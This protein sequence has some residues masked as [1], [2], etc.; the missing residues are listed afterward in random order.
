MSLFVITVLHPHRIPFYVMNESS[1]FEIRFVY[2]DLDDTLI[3]HKSAERAS[4]QDTRSELTYLQSVDIEEL[5][6][7][8]HLNN[9]RLWREYGEGNIDRPFLENARIEWTLKDVGIDINK[10]DEVR[11][12]YMKFY[13]LHWSWISGAEK[14]LQIISGKYPVGYLTNGFSEIQRGKFEKFELGK[15]SN[16][17]V[18]SEDVGFM[19]PS[20][21]IFAHATAKAGVKPEEILYV[22]DSFHSDIE[23]GNSYGWKTAWFV[24]N[25]DPEKA[26]IAD[27][28]FD[29]YTEL[30]AY[31]MEYTPA[32]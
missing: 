20:I 24:Q 7:A 11:E 25:P 8:Y 21:E 22:G 5:R 14:A 19:K 9:S 29:D 32:K 30:V 6:D 1:N 28:R 12:I 2:F 18:I 15:Y 26:R 17:C 13:K 3:D 4:L 27:Y 16:I 31:L 10:T 23:G